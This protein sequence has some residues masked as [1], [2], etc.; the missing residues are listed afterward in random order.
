MSNIR[1]IKN[2]CNPYVNLNKKTLEI[3]TLSW[4]AKGLWAY[5]LSRP[6]DWRTNVKHLV[7]IGKC[8]KDKIYKI[9]KELKDHDLCVFEQSKQNGRWQP[10]DYIIFESSEEFK[11]FFRTPK[12]SDTVNDTF[13]NENDETKKENLSESSDTELP[14]TENPDA[15]KRMN[16]TKEKEL[17]RSCKKGA[18]APVAA[19]PPPAHPKKNDPPKKKFIDH[20]FLSKE[21]HLKLLK[22]YGEAKTTLMIKKLDAY[23][24]SKGKKYK[25]HCKTII[26]WILRDEENERNSRKDGNQQPSAIEK[27]D[28]KIPTKKDK[29]KFIRQSDGTW[30]KVG[31]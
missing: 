3:E 27:S 7:S 19:A 30:K 28:K 20:V 15:Y 6:D 14:D 23:I 18:T 21:E 8:G 29:G 16:I 13:L 11:K 10:G 25:N 9:L 5:L 2:K 22:E 17:L 12:N 31:I 26:N 1:T 24:G 4:E